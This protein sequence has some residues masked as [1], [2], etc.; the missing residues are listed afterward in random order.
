L[1]KKHPAL[2]YTLALLPT[3]WD[4]IGS[5]ELKE[6]RNSKDLTIDFRGCDGSIQGGLSPTTCSADFKCR[7]LKIYSD[8]R[9]IFIDRAKANA[10]VSAKYRVSCPRKPAEACPSISVAQCAQQSGSRPALIQRVYPSSIS[11][12]KNAN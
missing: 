5:V 1:V 12:E 10:F 8:K 9:E 3:K 6:K 7:A 2:N 4:F 11:N